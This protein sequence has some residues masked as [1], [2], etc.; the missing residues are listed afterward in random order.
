MLEF[1]G[2]F[3]ICVIAFAFFIGSSEVVANSKG[4]SLFKTKNGE[5]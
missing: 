3:L 5:K 2:Q 4:Q 1:I